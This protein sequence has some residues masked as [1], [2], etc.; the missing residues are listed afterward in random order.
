MFISISRLYEQIDIL[1]PFQNISNQI[2]KLPRWQ[3]P[4]RSCRRCTASHRWAKTC[5]SCFEPQPPQQIRAKNAV[6]SHTMQNASAMHHFFQKAPT[7]FSDLP[8][9]G[10]LNQWLNQWRLPMSSPRFFWCPGTEGTLSCPNIEI[11]RSTSIT[12]S[13]CGVVTITAAVIL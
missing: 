4:R 12:L 10:W 3:S 6:V 7:G 11:P 13:F 2:I 1:H 8:F 9:F 5:N